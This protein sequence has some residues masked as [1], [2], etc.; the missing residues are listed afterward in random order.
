MFLSDLCLCK[1]LCSRG[2]P[3]ELGSVSVTRHA[4]ASVLVCV[5]LWV[6]SQDSTTSVPE[7]VQSTPRQPRFG[8]RVKRVLFLLFFGYYQWARAEQTRLSG[9]RRHNYVTKN[10]RPH[11][12][13]TGL[14]HPF[15]RKV[16]GNDALNVCWPFLDTCCC[17]CSFSCS[18]SCS[19]WCNI[20][21]QR[22]CTVT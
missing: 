5:F 6:K 16:P 9:S 7:Q 20:T 21:D 15:W 2:E 1:S 13:S 10:C 3:R 4:C 11:T 8:A 22:S 17:A 19:R 18:F 12:P 14:R